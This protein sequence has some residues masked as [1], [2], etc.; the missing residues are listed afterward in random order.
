MVFRVRSLMALCASRSL[1]LF[2]LSLLLSQKDVHG[3]GEGYGVAV[4]GVLYILLWGQVGHTP[5]RSAPTS[6][7]SFIGIG[8]D[9]VG[10][11]R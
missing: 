2:L 8:I 7:T 5:R 6:S 4:G 10:E 11:R 1:A 9:C 3:E